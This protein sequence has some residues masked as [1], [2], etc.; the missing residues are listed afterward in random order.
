[1]DSLPGKKLAELNYLGP[2]YASSGTS[3]GEG[4]VIYLF[5]KLHWNKGILFNP[6]HVVSPG[7]G[8]ALRVREF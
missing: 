2:V 4:E 7:E 1:M 8:A 3:P 5:Y 6:A